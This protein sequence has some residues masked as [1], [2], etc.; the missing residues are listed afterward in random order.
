MRQM[1][2]VLGGCSPDKTRPETA[3]A[4]CAVSEAGG[5]VRRT[6]PRALRRRR[7][8]HTERALLLQYQPVGAKK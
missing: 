6:S 3:S 8:R 1:R 7:R 4:G 2:A 5:G